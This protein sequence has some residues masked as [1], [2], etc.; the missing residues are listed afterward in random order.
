MRGY[1]V[2]E[3]ENAEEALETLRDETLDVDV[4]VTDVIMPGMN[5]PQLASAVSA[6]RPE[7][8]VLY[9]SGYT[10]DVLARQQTGIE[11]EL[12]EKPFTGDGLR[13]RV[14]AALRERN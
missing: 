8:R 11:T 1:K 6:H 3:A 4:F 7:I 9:M 14:A 13:A 12:I 10:A 2:I 5:G